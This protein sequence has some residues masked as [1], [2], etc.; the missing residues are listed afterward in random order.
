[1]TAASR[2]I[3]GLLLLLAGFGLLP[4]TTSAH[5]L[6]QNDAHLRHDIQILA[7]AGVITG[8]MGTWPVPREALLPILHR[9]LPV[10]S[11]DAREV[12]AWFRVR[13]LLRAERGWY[14]NLR[15]KGVAGEAEPP[16]GLA[17]FGNANPEGSE[18]SAS[19]AYQGE[20]LSFRLTGSWV[21]DPA[22]GREFR[23]DGSY[24]AAQ[25][26][27]WIVSA[28]AVPTYWGPG[29]SGSLILGNAARPVPGL[30]V[31]RAEP[32]AFRLPVLERLGPWTLHAFWGQLGSDRAV[33]RP[34]FL[35]ARFAFQPSP[36][37]ELGLSRTAIWDSPHTAR[38]LLDLAI[39]DRDRA[40]RRTTAE[41][42][43]GLDL[44][45]AFPEHLW[46]WAAY[47]QHIGDSESGRLPTQHI[48]LFGLESWGTLANDASYRVFLEYADT[49]ARFYSSRKLFN[50]AYESGGLPSGHRHRDRPLGYAT[51]NDSR[52]LTLG[53]LY[54]AANDHA[55]TVKLQVGTLNRDDSQRAGAGGNVIA[56]HKLRLVDLEGGYRWPLRH[57]EAGLGA[58]M[59]RID[60]AREGGADW[61]GRAWLKYEYQF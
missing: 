10:E 32:K 37:L 20:G 8:A 57:G 60:E 9:P 56:P 39:A 42:M 12:A 23:A 1:M 11:L 19:A 16:A 17:W 40:Q 7:D 14:G 49:T 4:A 58:G 15:V 41:Q 22:D 54:R 33:P 47:L 43:A 3:R 61:E 18:T 36:R 51:D 59:A 35:G 50:S 38:G 34:H 29:W 21:D 53:A 24:L 52:L 31:Q 30:T 6:P 25:L 46:P 44:R 5:W 2:T 55:A 28:G 26:G 27:N 45:L 13:R 48:G